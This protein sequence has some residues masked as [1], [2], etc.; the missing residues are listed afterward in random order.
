MKRFSITASEQYKARE[1]RRNH[2]MSA[3]GEMMKLN[4]NCFIEFPPT[5]HGNGKTPRFWVG[6]KVKVLSPEWLERHGECINGEFFVVCISKA[7]DGHPEKY[8]ILN[9]D[10][11]HGSAWFEA[12][13]LQMVATC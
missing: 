11:E 8:S 9:K 4:K 6:D 12:R 2:L 13:D 7:A 1:R 10:S 3:I 5:R